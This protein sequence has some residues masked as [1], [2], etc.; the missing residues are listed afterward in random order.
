MKRTAEP[1][2][3]ARFPL[4]L[5]QESRDKFAVKADALAGDL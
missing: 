5:D 3:I 4:G 2:L 1:Y